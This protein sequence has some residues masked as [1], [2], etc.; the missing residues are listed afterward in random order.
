M[1]S[2][3]RLAWTLGLFVW[4]MGISSSNSTDDISEG[5]S[6]HTGHPGDAARHLHPG[7][8]G[9]E[10]AS[11]QP[12]SGMQRLWKQLSGTALAAPRK[13]T[14]LCPTGP[15]ILTDGI[16][17]LALIIG[18][19]KYADPSISQLPGAAGDAQRIYDRLTDARGYNF[20]K[21]NVCLLQDQAATVEGFKQAFRAVLLNRAQSGDQAVLY[22]A[23]HGSYTKDLNGDEPDELDET[24]ILHDSRSKGVHDLV[25][26]ELNGMLASLYARTTHLVAI[27]DSCNSGTVTRDGME[28]VRFQ[29][30]EADYQSERLIVADKAGSASDSLPETV[31]GTGDEA[32]GMST[33]AMPEAVFVSAA[34]DGTSAVEKDRAGLF[35]SS[36][37][38][39][40]T[41]AGGGPLTW[42]Q[43]ALRVPPLI[44]AA[45]GY[46]VPYFQGNLNQAAFGLQRLSRP[47]GWTVT[48]VNGERFSLKG[49]M[50]PGWSTGALLRVYSGTATPEETRSPAKAMATLELQSVSGLEAQAVR[51]D[52]PRPGQAPIQPGAL[53]V[54]VRPG[55][56]SLRL[57]VRMRPSNSPGGIPPQ[58]VHEIQQ[59]IETGVD[60]KDVIQVKTAEASFELMMRKD[61][62]LQLVGPEGSIRNTFSADRS[63]EAAQVARTLWQ[64]ARQQAIL[65]LQGEGG[66][67][68]VN[69]S[70]LKVELIPASQQS[71][72]TQGVWIPSPP[73]SEQLLPLCHHARIKVS[74]SE[75]APNP[76][77]VG[78]L[79]LSSDGGLYGFPS[80]GSLTRLEPGSSHTFGAA[81]VIHAL[82]PL[83]VRDYLMLFGT[84]EREPI[85]WRDFTD[86]A[87]T[88]NGAIENTHNRSSLSPLQQALLRYV[89]GT[90][91][92][93]LGGGGTE[94]ST[95]TSTILPMRTI[96]NTR[97]LGP[98]EETRPAELNREYTVPHFDLR[99][100]L[101][102]NSESALA[103][104]L[105]KE[106]WLANISSTDGVPY[107]QHD[108][109]Q[110]TDALNLK[111]GIDC[112]RAIWFAFT[113]SGLPYNTGDQYLT[114]AQMMGHNS[115]MSE[116][117]ESCQADAK[118]Q[119]GDILVYRDEARHRG[120]V[121]M[122]IDPELRIAWG[123][124]GW[125]GNVLEQ[126]KGMSVEVD[127]GVEY[128]RIKYK[129][130]WER[131]DRTTM[132][133]VACWRYKQFAEEARSPDGLPGTKA[134][135]NAC[136]PR[137]CRE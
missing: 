92:V 96:A 46:Q 87:V 116:F 101:P 95:W 42:A 34:A 91:G 100:Y 54:L 12:P 98:S 28:T 7:G 41:E 97:F 36:L 129:K 104:I 119:L 137:H 57:T 80:D 68:F 2:R 56:A 24:L 94:Q 78:G 27:F 69:N 23:G 9:F 13:P 79:L 120:H 114:T 123:S 59:L 14:E 110:K 35:T 121:V 19:S 3:K 76:L 67:D 135:D 52:E 64:Y 39:V 89:S 81:D 65:Q 84:P 83:G 4:G 38:Q 43:V 71:P 113:R 30:P 11:F 25:D 74:L 15:A 105:R 133:R 75:A 48:A 131:W 61:G 111:Q 72:C 130:D 31:A 37:L 29:S 62:Q 63:L 102:D 70:S 93:N 50:L 109:S 8:N 115:P 53:A 58:R 1:R 122:V 106:Y 107:H 26:D 47:I 6:T 32:A 132:K 128:Q 49:S 17:R 88:G 66:D 44:S 5:L 77:M 18:I 90:R 21:E 99:P 125:D 40:L 45:H 124:H 117:F 127:R 126:Q 118:I 85:Q 86:P 103:R 60:T 20:P 108:W 55:Q 134:L 16:R 22:F 136:E 10:V 73:N 51:M 33:A 112:S 82:P